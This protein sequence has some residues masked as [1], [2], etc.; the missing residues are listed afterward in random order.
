MTDIHDKMWRTNI[1]SNYCLA[2]QKNMEEMPTAHANTTA[3]ALV[4]L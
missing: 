4:S 3:D 2:E 1:G